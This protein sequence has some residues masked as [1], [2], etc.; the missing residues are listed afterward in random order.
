LANGESVFGQQA[1]LIQAQE[2]PHGAHKSAI[3]DA[4]GEA[5]P[6]LFFQGLEEA[7][8]DACGSSNFLTGH[9][10]HFPLAL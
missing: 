4:T 10:T 7:R 1:F 2:T 3:E 5:V 9:P 8:A 6:L